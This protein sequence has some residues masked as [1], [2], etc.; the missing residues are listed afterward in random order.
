MPTEPVVGLLER[1][2]YALLDENYHDDDAS[3]K[4]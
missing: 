4:S 2:A 3:F 1:L